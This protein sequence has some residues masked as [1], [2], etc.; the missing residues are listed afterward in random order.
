VAIEA[1]CEV[2]LAL[3]VTGMEP[4]SVLRFEA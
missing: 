2:D 4:L 1:I 3:L